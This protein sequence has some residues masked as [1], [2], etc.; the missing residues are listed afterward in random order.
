MKYQLSKK[1]QETLVYNVKELSAKLGISLIGA[2]NLVNQEGFP[3]VRIGRRIVIP[4]DAL[5]RWLEKQC[6][7]SCG[8]ISEQSIALRR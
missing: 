4:K 8:A 5:D 3:S 2:Y 7:D 6:C 1:A